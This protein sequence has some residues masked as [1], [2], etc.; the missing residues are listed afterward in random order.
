MERPKRKHSVK[1]LHHRHSLPKGQPRKRSFC[2][3]FE[4]HYKQS[5]LPDNGTCFSCICRPAD[6]KHQRH[7]LYCYHVFILMRFSPALLQRLKESVPLS[8]LIGHY[9]PLQR[10]GKDIKACCPFHKEKTP[11]F[12]IKDEKE[13]YHCFGC[14]AHGDH[15]RF[16]EQMEG[17]SFP[18]AVER[19]AAMG[20]ISLPK[21]EPLSPAVKQQAE[22]QKTAY[23]LLQEAASYF[24]AQY[25]A[26][27]AAAVRNYVSSRGL[28]H[29]TVEQFGLG[30]A[31][32]TRDGLKQYLLGK[33][34]TEAMAIEQGLLIQ[35]EAGRPSY[36]RFRG[37]LM[38]PIWDKKGRTIAFGGRILGDGQ[39]KYLNSP[40]TSLFHKSDVLYGW[41]LARNAAYQQQQLLLV[42]GY[43]DVIALH[44]AGIAHVVA[45]LGTALGE[46]HLKQCWQV[47][48]TPT[49]CLDGDAAGLRAMERACEVA[50]PLLQPGIGL[51]VVL[52][53]QGED[54]DTL[55][56]TGGKTALEGLLRQSRPLSQLL[57]E[58][59]RQRHAPGETA[60]PEQKAALAAALD[61]QAERIT[62]P[63]V[64]SFF[65]DYF[66]QQCRFG[67]RHHHTSAGYS[68]P[69]FGKS[70]SGFGNSSYSGM[71]PSPSRRLQEP[72]GQ[73]WEKLLLATLLI[74]P[75][76]LE[77]QQVENTLEQ[78]PFTRTDYAA[79][80]DILLLAPI[81]LPEL[82]PHALQPFLRQRGQQALA[83]QLLQDKALQVESALRPNAD[84]AQALLLWQR[85]EVDIRHLLQQSAQNAQQRTMLQ[86]VSAENWEQFLH[87][88]QQTEDSQDPQA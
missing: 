41:H 56:K 33:G 77:Q 25:H 84:P 37:R 30:F 31:P 87:V 85:L 40:E 67:L 65:K 72:S 21:P 61:A 81:E 17:L 13:Y 18:E 5:I 50:L 23:E 26:P 6:V 4:Q 66:R 82:T 52:L 49:L 11:S 76:L 10:R 34:F 44:Q 42:E 7:H 55:V 60:S 71:R 32:D 36:D 14:G 43:M 48:P 3:F 35:P 58:Q 73:M 27:Q 68:K 53:P 12:H 62:H 28:S 59:Y 8:Q 86:D 54:P 20:G 51:N 70:G 88:L 2:T 64:K 39:P 45:P 78:A 75:H 74:H 19:I 63:D 9:V 24:T 16:L 47:L 22:A 79:L 15:F 57:W 46:S 83:Q 29:Q 80:R 1:R 38:F 69:G